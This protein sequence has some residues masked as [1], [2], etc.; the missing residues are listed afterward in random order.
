MILCILGTSAIQGGKLKQVARVLT[1]QKR[2]KPFVNK[3]QLPSQLGQ[4][5]K[6]SAPLQRG[7]PANECPEYDTK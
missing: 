4:Q 6:P 5:N 7:N 3:Y 1:T 2:E